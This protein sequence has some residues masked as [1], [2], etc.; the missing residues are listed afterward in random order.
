M[1]ERYNK[2]SDRGIDKVYT[3]IE[4]FSKLGLRTLAIG[5]R[6]ISQQEFN[7]WSLKYKVNIGLWNRII[8]GAKIQEMAQLLEVYS[9]LFK[10][11]LSV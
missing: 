8:Y 9:L 2:Y 11:P 5:F 6:E 4:E 3:H 10:L 1:Y 7:S